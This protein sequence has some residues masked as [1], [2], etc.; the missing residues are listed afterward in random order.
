MSMIKKLLAIPLLVFSI[1]SFAQKDSTFSRQL[2]EVV[3]TASKTL[4]KQSQTGKIVTVLDQKIISNNAGRSLSEL[5]N[6]QAGFFINGANNTP[7]TNLD[8]Y[9]RGAG[10]GNMLI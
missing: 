8:V 9:F 10:T 1:H 4:L 3:V 2:D 6:T 7:G 5:L